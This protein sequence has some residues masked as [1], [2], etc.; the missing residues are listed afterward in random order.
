VRIEKGG[1]KAIES[2]NGDVKIINRMTDEGK[3][4][5]DNTKGTEIF[6]DT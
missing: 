3:L 4:V 6:T 2:S 5:S 1:T